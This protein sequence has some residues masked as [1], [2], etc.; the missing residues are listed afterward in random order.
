MNRKYT[1]FRY[2]LREDGH[3]ICRLGLYQG[4]Y[5][6]IEVVQFNDIDLCPRGQCWGNNH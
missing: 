1:N 4:R 5:D 6:S 3:K 2:R